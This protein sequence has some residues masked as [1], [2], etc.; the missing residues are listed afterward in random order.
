MSIP[1]SSKQSAIDNDLHKF[2]SFRMGDENFGIGI[3]AIREI[4]EY[5]G[6]TPVPMMPDFIK[7]A[8]NLRGHVVSVM[9]LAVRLG[10][11]AQ[12]VG[13]RTCIVIVEVEVQGVKMEVGLMVEAV[14][15]VLDIAPHEID[16]APSF[17]GTVRTDFLHGMGKIGDEFLILLDIN[18]VLTLKDVELLDEIH[19][20]ASIFEAA[21]DHDVE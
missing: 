8:I 17:G 5:G 2:L 19:S 13:K 10:R 9:D 7:G 1:S 18:N 16:P 21:D 6:M 11:K 14:N 4:I 15:E 20:D 12:Q 3:L